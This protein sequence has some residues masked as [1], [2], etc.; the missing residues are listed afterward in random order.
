[1][2]TKRYYQICG[3][4]GVR[5]GYSQETFGLQENKKTRTNN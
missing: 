5:S 1:M 2:S 3:W 4:K